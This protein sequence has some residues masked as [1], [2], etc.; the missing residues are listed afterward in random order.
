MKSTRSSGA[1]LVA[2]TTKNLPAMQE[3]RVQ[4]LS[5]EDPWTQECLPTPLFL[6]GEF[7][8]QRS[9]ATYRL[10]GRTELDTLLLLSRFSRVRLC[11]T[12]QTVAHQAP[13]SLGFC[14]QEHWSGL[15]FPSPMYE[16]WKWSQSVMSDPLWP[17]GLQPTRLLHPQE[18]LGKS[19]A[20]GCHFLLWEWDM[21]E[22][23][24]HTQEQ[25]LA[26]CWLALITMITMTLRLICYS[27]IIGIS[28]RSL[29][30]DK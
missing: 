28:K 11:A 26:Q 23:L 17:H 27:F 5:Q 20:V 29:E 21:T 3:T 10:W 13:L 25:Y 7:H 24:T 30:T 18:F 6:P 16:K 4:S 19:T 12:P 2:Q 14:R 1:S 15:P 9:F 22:W 8:G